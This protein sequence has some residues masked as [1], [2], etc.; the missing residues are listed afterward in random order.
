MANLFWKTKASTKSLLE[1]PFKTEEEFEKTIFGTSELLE[2]VFLIKRQIRGGNKAGIPDIIGLDSDG[3]VCIIEMKNVTVDASI[4]PQ[5]LHY[6][7]WAETNPDSIKSLWL[8]SENKPDNLTI[9]WDNLQVRILI[10]APAILRSTLLAVVKITYQVDLIEVKR[11]VE[12]DNQLLLIDKLEQD[13][14]SRVKPTSGL[15]TYDEAFYKHEYNKTSAEHFLKYA[16]EVEHLVEQRGWSLETKFNKHYC[17][18]KAGFFNAFG[19]QWIS[20]KTF[21]FFFKITEKE[22]KQ[23]K[24][25]MTKYDNQWK[26]AMYYIEPG[27]TKTINLGQ[28][29][30]LA[31]KKRTGD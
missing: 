2:D 18:F 1:T 31:Y 28:L 10:I 24:V 4:I 16:K 3:N 5:V 26:Q 30:E 6:A 12:G 19:I 23:V 17:G 14:K 11:W 7:I 27:V 9:P 21:A 15:Q 22:A 13:V 20:S 29:F 8:Q 25:P